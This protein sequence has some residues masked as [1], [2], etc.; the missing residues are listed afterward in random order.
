MLTVG[1][2]QKISYKN[3]A[4]HFWYALFLNFRKKTNMD[5]KEILKMLKENAIKY[6]EK[7]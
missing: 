3:R 2:Q 4:Y 6:N 7:Q 1:G 5:K